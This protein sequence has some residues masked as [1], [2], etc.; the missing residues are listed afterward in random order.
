MLWHQCIGGMYYDIRYM[1]ITMVLGAT[2]LYNVLLVNYMLQKVPEIFLI[3]N[4]QMEQNILV[5]VLASIS[6]K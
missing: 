6:Q 1:Q 2:V 4:L 5:V 3:Q